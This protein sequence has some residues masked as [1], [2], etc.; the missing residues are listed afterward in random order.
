MNNH[1]GKKHGNMAGRTGNT[2]DKKKKLKGLKP[3]QRDERQRII[4]VTQILIRY[5]FNI[6]AHKGTSFEHSRIFFCL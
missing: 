3:T 6:Y 2:H 4:N 1:T 5:R